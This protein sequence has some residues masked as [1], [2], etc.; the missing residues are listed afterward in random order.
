M[1]NTELSTLFTNKVRGYMNNGYIINTK[2]FSGSDGTQR[3]DLIK[4]NHFI[5]VYLESYY[6]GESCIAL[7][8]GEKVLTPIEMKRADI[9]WKNDLNIIKEYVF[10][11]IGI[12]ND[13]YV[14]PKE[15]EKIEKKIK[16]RLG[17][18]GYGYR[19]YESF[20][21]NDKAIDIVI[22]FIKRQPKCKSVKRNEIKQVYKQIYNNGKVKYLVYV[23]GN[24][25]SLS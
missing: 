11:K 2:T 20:D 7:R 18:H 4:G 21:L 13:Y 23:R 22:P 14:T 16:E 12:R 3:V 19:D 10:I 6:D 8:I 9:I 1:T 5:R 24:V 25:Y 17:N 15:Y